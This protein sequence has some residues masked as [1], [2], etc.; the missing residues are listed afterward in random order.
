MMAWTS[1]MQRELGLLLLPFQ[2]TL[3]VSNPLPPRN[4][5]FRSANGA[6]VVWQSRGEDNVEKN[7]FEA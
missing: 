1:E 7:C 2:G 3:E 4:P 5:L 6:F